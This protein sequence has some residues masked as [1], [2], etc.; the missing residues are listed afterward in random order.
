MSTDADDE[1]PR[2]SSDEMDE[3]RQLQMAYLYLCHLEETRL[4]LSSCI[5]EEMPSAT[6][7]E[8]SLRNGV[9]L[10]RLSHF[11]AP[12][13]VPLRKIYDVD[14]SVHR[15]RG[16]CFRHTDNIN[17]W[18]NA[19][20]AIGFPE[21]F[22][23][24]P[25]DLY[26]KKNMPKVIYCLH[27]LSLYL[28]K[29]GKAPRIEKLMGKLRFSDEE[30]EQVRRSLVLNA[31]VPMPAFSL[32][33]GIL[34]KE[35]SADSSAVIA[36]NT[37]IDKGEEDLLFET[38]SAPAAQLKGVRP[39]NVHRYHEVLERAKASK[40]KQRA[41][42][43]LEGGEDE[44]EDMYERLLSL[45]EVQGYVLETN[46]NVLLGQIDD[47]MNH[48]DVVLFGHL[49]LTRKDLGVH[50]I[51]EDNV[52]AY[53]Q[54]LAK[55]KEDA[56]ANNNPF[57]LSRSDLQVAVQLANEKVE[58]ETLLEAAIEAVNMSLDCGRAEDTLEALR[59]P[60]ARLPGVY[61]LAA[62]LYHNQFAFIRREAGHNLSHEELIGGVRILNAIAEV[63]FALKA[64]GSFDAAACLENPHAHIADV[65][66]QCHDRY[67]A[68][69]KAVLD[70]RADGF[71]T[72]TEIQEIVNE[73]NAAEDGE[74]DR[75][76]ALE[77]INDAVALGT[78]QATMEALLAPAAGIQHLSRDHVLLYQDLLEVKQRSLDD[79]RP[80]SVDDIQSVID[81]AN[82]VAVE[83]SNMCIGLATLNV[84]VCNQSVEDVR[85]GLESLRVVPLFCGD[86]A[87]AIEAYMRELR[88][89]FLE[90]RTPFA[91]AP[92]EWFAYLVRPGLFFNLNVVQFRSEWSP[93][94][95]AD[96]TSFLSQD[97][98][99]AAV[100]KVNERL[101][102]ARIMAQLS[103]MITQFQARARGF[104]IRSAVREQ[105]AFYCQHLDDI[106]RLQSWFRAVRQRRRYRRMLYELEAL[107]PFV[108]RLQ[109]YARGFLARKKVLELYE[110]YKDRQDVV[111]FVQTRY[112]GHRALRDYQLLTR[113]TPT[114]P[115]L[116]RF[117]HMLDISEHDLSEEMELQK[118]KEKVVATIRHNQAL[119]KEVF[120]MDIRIGLLVRNCITLEDVMSHGA[121]K[122]D[123]ALAAVKSDWLHT[124]GGGLT[125][126]S[127]RSRQRLEAYQHVF[128]LL[129][130]DPHYLAKLIFVIPLAMANNFVESVIYSVYNYGSTPRD[131]YLLLRLFR[132][133]LQEEVRSKL[134]KPSD[135]L[136]GN[137]L[138][139]RMVVGFFRTRGGH[140]CL[141]L[142]LSP[143]VKGVLDDKE[144]K[145]DLN[146]VDIYKKWVNDMETTSGKPSGLKYEVN[147]EEALQHN[148]V[149]KML[150]NSVMQLENKAKMFARTIAESKSK[151]PY[152]MLYLC[153]VLKKA[154]EEKFPESAG[155]EIT[156]VIGN[157]LYYRYLNPGIVAPESFG[158]VKLEPECPVTNVQRRNLGNIS[159]ILSSATSGVPYRQKHAYQI[160]LNNLIESCREILHRFFME[161][162]EVSEPEDRFSVDS[163][164]EATYISPPTITLTALELRSTHRLLLEHEDDIAPDPKDPLHGLLEDLGPEPTLE[165]LVGGGG[166]SADT[167]DVGVL[168][169]AKVSLSLYGK[170]SEE[171]EDVPETDQLLRDTKYMI[172]ELLKVLRHASSVDEILHGE[173]GPELERAFLEAQATVRLPKV[174]TASLLGR[175]K[176]GSL[177]AFR[178]ALLRNL[179]MLEGR[180]IA[181]AQDDYQA[182]MSSI[183]TDI[184]QKRNHRVNRKRELAN[185]AD[186]QRK[187]DVK[188]RYY[189]ETLD[190]YQRYVDACL[191]N[192]SAGKSSRRQSIGPGGAGQSAGDIQHLKPLKSRSALKYSGW[193]LHEKGILLEVSGLETNQLKSVSFE[194]APTDRAGVFSVRTKFLGVSTD[195]FT[196]DI[197][198]LLRQQY[199]GVAVTNLCDRARVNNNLL[200]FFLNKKFYGK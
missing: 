110:H 90:K 155:E 28:F 95:K 119:E 40:L 105:Y 27:A 116:Q 148:E 114:V 3:K 42:R 185:L 174:S 74:A 194:I 48:G 122:K 17:H 200:L 62:P 168:S 24:D 159:K 154:L 51:V 195:E 63:N 7:L 78:P 47:A 22:F 196:L 101:E 99:R 84:G 13:E 103:P 133:A 131:E 193:K 49:L 39:E 59:D 170:F 36:I 45:A 123:T 117:L 64:S 137:P 33:D 88:A 134:E 191:A 192:L 92:I 186:T 129:Q 176:Y 171:E 34:A 89:V 83:A 15:E 35:T 115:V 14:Q 197:Q 125:A 43:H 81:T 8:E 165:D 184:L 1:E 54:V 100:L 86:D 118:V 190:Y 53:F 96:H 2:P 31:E 147:E 143:L 108:V 106:V 57:T 152:G 11:F 21:H 70:E 144:L 4:W 132:F 82:Q 107:V 80:L 138:V 50:D 75:E 69:L 32:I 146:P 156:K 61:P 25:F 149:Y 112:R 91:F 111:T 87:A 30:V 38:L 98:V 37:A 60:A 44:A 172:V 140:N 18:L 9:Y 180:G 198:D 93:T 183:A 187:L 16:L 56:Q 141:E 157:I 104:L 179:D 162:C 127:R 142:L 71:L 77:R 199:E 113:A 12:E 178:K 121:K 182:L 97:D 167:M 145:I 128:Y 163:Y 164:S 189:E 20:R 76:D 5:E 175:R 10:A 153:K 151:I 67:L 66:P 136:R 173:A 177:S 79:E 94:P 6:R 65:R 102:E 41:M 166:A 181:T 109:S 23:P 68:A 169:S 158:V 85:G 124:S 160:R 29:L 161:A 73:V 150:H 26:E 120:Q 55:I 139:V 58:E 72:H 46:V 130:V 126:L 19:M 135:I 188:T 52:P